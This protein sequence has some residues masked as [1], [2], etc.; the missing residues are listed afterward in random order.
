MIGFCGST[1]SPFLY[2]SIS[3]G[4]GSNL[5]R[6]MI[7]IDSTPCGLISKSVYPMAKYPTRASEYLDCIGDWG[8]RINELFNSTVILAPPGAPNPPAAPGPAAVLLY[9]LTAV[10]SIFN[11]ND[12]TPI[13]YDL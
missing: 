10:I 4:F 6:C 8:S 1:S 12:R 11:G 2:L 7:R 3:S 5:Q 13:T 9:V